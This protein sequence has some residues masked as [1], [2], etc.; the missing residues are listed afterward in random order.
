MEALRMKTTSMRMQPEEQCLYIRDNSLLSNNRTYSGRRYAYKNS[1][2]VNGINPGNMPN[3]TLSYNPI[4]VESTLFGIDIQGNIRNPK[5]EKKLPISY[6]PKK[7]DEIHFFEKNN[8]VY[9][10]EPLVIDKNQRPVIP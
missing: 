2:P 9:I 8:Y 5:I 4:D 10:P 7:L 3:N 1:F 6:E